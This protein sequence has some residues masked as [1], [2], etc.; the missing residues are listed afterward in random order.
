MCG[1]IINKGDNK[2]YISIFHRAVEAITLVYIARY[3]A[4][5]KSLV[6]NIYIYTYIRYLSRVFL[7]IGQK[8]IKT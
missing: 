1:Q 7:F 6:F 3:R 4:E 5:K 2:H 8:N